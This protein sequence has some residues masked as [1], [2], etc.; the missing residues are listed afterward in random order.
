[1]VNFIILLFKASGVLVLMLFGWGF[2]A[3]PSSSSNGQIK[4]DTASSAS[5]ENSDQNIK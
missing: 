4:I 1:M 2:L 5:T 3:S